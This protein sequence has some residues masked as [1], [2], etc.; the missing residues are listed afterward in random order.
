MDDCK[1]LYAKRTKALEEAR[2]NH[3]YKDSIRIY[4]EETVYDPIDN[5]DTPE[6]LKKLRT[7]YR[8]NTIEY[9]NDLYFQTMEKIEDIKK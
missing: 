9:L 1:K 5:K 8:G 7:A 2:R 6:I 4:N 3:N